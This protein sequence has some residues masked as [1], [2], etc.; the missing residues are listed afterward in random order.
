MNVLL[1]S[2]YVFGYMD[3]AVDEM[4]NQGHEVEVYYYDKPPFEFSYQNSFHKGISGIK[5]VV[6]INERKNHR[7]NFLVTKLKYK[8]F[9]KTIVIHGQYLEDKTLAFLQSISHERIAF[10]FDSLGKM[11]RQK[12][13]VDFFDTIYSYDPNDCKN[14]GFRFL[15]NF[16]P[17]ER[18]RNGQYDY[19]I[20]NIS[21]LDQ[22]LEIFQNLANYL[23]LQ[24]ISYQFQLCNSRLK[25]LENFTINPKR[26]DAKEILPLIKNCK[27]M[28]DIQRKDQSGLSFRPF[29][30]M[31]NQKK[32]I[33]NH[34]AIKEYDFYNPQNIWIIDEENI[35]IPNEFLLSDYQKIPDEI[36][37]QYTLKSWVQHILND[38]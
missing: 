37:Q 23:N 38:N 9:D 31:G 34:Q 6:G 30:A 7:H 29:E 35:Q 12:R 24:H 10:F 32:L 22:R 5:K 13:I 33:T 2:S 27:I 14:E 20:F 36:Y 1:I 28:V 18:Y 8:K 25:H 11:P 26:I 21:S 15:N 4:R 17:T 16:I 19:L 3:F